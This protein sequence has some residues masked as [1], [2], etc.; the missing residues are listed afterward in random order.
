MAK[1]K[2]ADFSEI[3]EGGIRAYKVGEKKIAIYKIGGKIYATSNECSHEQCTLDEHGTIHF[4][5]VECTCHGS[6]FEIKTGQ[7]I[8]PPATEKI[9][10][11]RVEV[12]GNDIMVEI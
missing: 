12:N 11:Y 4:D 6:Q 1:I 2:I 9:A 10:T 3:P 7:V 8:M 5:L